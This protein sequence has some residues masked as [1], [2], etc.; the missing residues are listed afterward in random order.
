MERAAQMQD[1][2]WR[3]IPNLNIENLGIEENFW[4]QMASDL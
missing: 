1:I 2:F 4:P 3:Q